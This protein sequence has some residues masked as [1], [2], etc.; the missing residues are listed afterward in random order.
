MKESK[1]N[2]LWWAK[3][4]STCICCSRSILTVFDIMVCQEDV[5]KEQL[6]IGQNINPHISMKFSSWIYQRTA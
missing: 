2:L 1:F 6:S 5:E 3:N 4:S